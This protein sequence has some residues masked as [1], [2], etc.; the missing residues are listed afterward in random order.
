MAAG[1][2]IFLILVILFLL[3]IVM[4]SAVKIV[5]QGFIGILM[6]FGKYQHEMAPGFHLV[7]PLIERVIIM[8]M[9]EQVLDVPRQE[10]IT[11]DNSPVYVDAIIYIKVMDAKRA[12][13]SVNDY[14][15][16]SVK[17]AQTSLRAI[18]GDMELD[19]IL[20]NREMINTKLR[21]KLDIDTD[22][23][24]V[25]VRRVEIKEVDPAAAVKSAMEE[26][27]SSERRRRAAIL[28]AAGEKRSAILV[29]EG[30]KRSAILRA[31]GDRQSKILRAE[32][33]RQSRILNSQGEAQALRIISLGATPLD[34]KSLTYL[35]LNTLKAMAHGKATKIIFPFEIS[36]LMESASEYIGAGRT[37]PEHKLSDAST[38]EKLI[39]KAEDVLGNI[40]SQ[41]ELQKQIDDIDD[42]MEDIET[43]NQNLE[44]IRKGEM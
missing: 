23:W 16:A 9:R 39:G 15:M 43:E 14:R 13:F 27:T 29:A 19:E 5:N 12:E 37:I 8:D 28:R 6:R 18:I 41:E 33:D 30:E 38:L 40:P 36:K 42:E 1:T 20:Y 10:V 7:I 34:Q 4:I 25:Q 31:E 11:K 32:G 24:G 22:D 2:W 3:T 35:S 17:L 21:D 26:Q 44:K